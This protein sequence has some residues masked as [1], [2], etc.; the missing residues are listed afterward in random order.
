MTPSMGEMAQLEHRNFEKRSDHYKPYNA[1]ATY[2]VVDCDG[3]TWD[4]AISEFED[5]SCEQ[6]DCYMSGQWGG[7]THRLIV[8]DDVGKVVGGAIVVMFSAPVVG[9]GLA[10]VK[11]GPVWRRRGEQ[12]DAKTYKAVVKALIREFCDRRGALLSILPRPSPDYEPIEKTCLEELGFVTRRALDDPDRYLVRIHEDETSQS[13]ALDQKWRYNLRKALK[14][15]LT[16]KCFSDDGGDDVFRSLHDEMTAR[17]KFSDS[18]ALSIMPGVRAGLNRAMQ[19]H[20]FIAYHNDVP[21][22]GAI[23]A[24]HGDTAYYLF[25]ATSHKALPLKAGYALQWEILQ[26]L[27]GKNARWYDLGGTLA[28]PGLHQF[29]KGLVGKTGQ[30][31]RLT[32]EMDFWT[33]SKGR[34]LAD[35][36]FSARK[37]RQWLRG[38]PA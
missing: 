2:A 13:R 1:A 26:W 6:T 20:T 14:N 34:A 37:L 15:N 8:R 35:A 23:I 38:H 24:V 29:K 17:K 5:I 11:F 18:D 33:K 4:Q 21:I 16:I 3:A 30:I 27:Q 22:A 10:Y 9:S 32:G 25:G 31:W 12:Y 28:E 36:F 7:R 19:P